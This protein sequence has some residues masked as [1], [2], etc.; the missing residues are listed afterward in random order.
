MLLD[1]PFILIVDDVEDNREMYA[2]Y[3]RFAGF[4][5]VTAAN[6]EE[7]LEQAL[8][9]PPDAVVLDLTMP[10]LDGW[11]LAAALRGDA[12]TQHTRIVVLS[13]H[14]LTGTE[15]GALKAG[16]HSF[17][18]KPCLPEDLAAEVRRLLGQS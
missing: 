12:R 3:L 1:V 10:R 14:A 7:G 11:A 17:L 6:G 8:A 18:T 2:E 15:E 4:E 16:A 5:V 9:K 13:G